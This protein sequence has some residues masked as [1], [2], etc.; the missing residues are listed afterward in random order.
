[1]PVQDHDVPM[2]FQSGDRVVFL[3][4]DEEATIVDTIPEATMTAVLDAHQDG[5]SAS[6]CHI[7]MENT[8]IATPTSVTTAPIAQATRSA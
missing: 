1:M 8:T 7:V 4:N 3:A 5:A 2:R 6:G